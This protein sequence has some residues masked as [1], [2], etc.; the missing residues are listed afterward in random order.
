MKLGIYG[1]GRPLP[2]HRVLPQ[3]CQTTLLHQFHGLYFNIIL[4]IQPEKEIHCHQISPP[5]RMSETE[6]FRTDVTRKTTSFPPSSRATSSA[7]SII[8]GNSENPIC[9]S[10]S[11][12]DEDFILPSVKELAERRQL[13]HAVKEEPKDNLNVLKNES[14]PVK[15]EYKV[16]NPLFYQY[17]SVSYQDHAQFLQK[18]NFFLQQH[19]HHSKKIGGLDIQER[20]KNKTGVV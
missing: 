16:F 5:S 15:R 4:Y 1:S 14:V 8:P 12:E 18:L 13:N 10:D 11:D 9:I 2:R 19:R 3:R 20:A 6:D 17:L 7:T